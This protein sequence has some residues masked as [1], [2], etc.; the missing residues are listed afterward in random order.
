MNSPPSVPANLTVTIEGTSAIL[1]WDNSTDNNTPA[2]SIT[3][4]IYLGVGGNKI[5]IV[6]PIAD[7][8]DRP[9]SEKLP[10]RGISMII[11]G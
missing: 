9:G 11:A 10:D 3:Y 6:T 4:N 7:L 2:E 8:S 5:K 1:R